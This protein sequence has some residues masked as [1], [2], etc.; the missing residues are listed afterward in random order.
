MDRFPRFWFDK[1]F[2]DN[3]ARLAQVL[4]AERAAGRIKKWDTS[5]PQPFLMLRGQLIGSTICGGIKFFYDN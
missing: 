3:R 2:P 1:R 4:L 5:T